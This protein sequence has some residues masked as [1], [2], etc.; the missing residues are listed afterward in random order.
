MRKQ[1]TLLLLLLFCFSCKQN[2]EPHDKVVIDRLCYVYNL[3]S[4]VNDRIWK[5]FDDNK[6]DVPLIYYGDSNCYV[7]NPTAKFMNQYNPELIFGD[8]AIKIYKT[9]L[10]DSI[11]FHMHVTVS[12]DNA[13]SFDYMSPFIRCSDTELATKI[14]P[15]VPS[16]EVWATMIMH[17][18]FHGFQFKHA[19]YLDYYQGMEMTQDTLK[20][21]YLQNSWY[22]ESID[23]ENDMLLSAIDSEDITEMHSFVNSFFELREQRRA[24]TKQKF[25][26]DITAIE[27]LFETMEGTARYVEYNLYDVFSTKRPDIEMMKSDTLYQSYSYFKDFSFDENQWLYKTGSTY[28]YA[29]GFNILRLLDLLKI[30]YQP[31]LFQDNIS[32][33]DILR[34]EVIQS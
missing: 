8:A 15:D 11:P 23:R 12:F 5:G 13:D 24:T 19:G 25:N 26:A 31:K 20:S 10:L 28:Y 1:I 4:V 3:K 14:I 16:T 2:G 32:L 34:T 7:V 9:P 29:I 18:Y 30:D 33:E 6:Y 17:E 21:L 27:Q 22:K